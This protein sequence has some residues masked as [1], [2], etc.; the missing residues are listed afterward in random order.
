M[1]VGIFIPIGNN[2]WLISKNAPQ[3][4]PTFD[5]N[6]T[7][8][9]RAEHYGFE[10]ALSMIKLRGFGGET[11]FW[12]HN[13]ESFTLMAG[14]AAVTDKIQ[15]FA[16]AAT[17]TIPPAIVA[18]M[19]S[20]IDSISHGRFGVNLV[21]G[22]QKPEYSQMGLWPGDEFFAN[23]YDY[24]SEY[25]TVL[26]DLWTT[27]TCDMKG[28]YFQMDDCRVSPKPQADMKIICAGQSEAGMAFTA[29]YADYNF[30]FGKGVNTP[31]AFAPTV[32][33]LEKATADSG[34]D[35]TSVALFMVIAADTDD[36]ARARWESYK[37]GV[38]EEAVA[39]LGQQGAAD[40]KSKGDT[41]IRQMADPTSAVNIN[42]GTLVGSFATVAGMLDEI[43]E[44]PATSGVML[45][46]DDFVQGIEDF[47]QKIQPLMK[48]RKHVVD[49]LENAS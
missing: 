7:I 19:A 13:M 44:I 1:N 27:G 32:E 20:T 28:E 26:R 11:E 40:T 6:K 23:R 36:E 12:E 42:M 45:T 24:L 30:C 16:T 48:S 9:Q 34:R 47:G 35:V 10:F 21:T 4:M 39:W 22:W 38:D 46:F 25:A 15:L 2:G 17:L 18:R 8:V 41:N 3:Y 33:R 37:D 14:L 43:A 31:K 5:L 29:K 49:M